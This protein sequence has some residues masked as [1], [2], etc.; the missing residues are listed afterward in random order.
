MKKA[1]IASL[2]ILALGLVFNIGAAS[3]QLPGTQGQV[4]MDAA[5]QADYSAAM[6]KLEG[7]PAQQ[8]PALEAYLAKYPKSGV[9]DYV[10]QKIMVDY[11][12]VDPAKAITAADNVLASTPDN[13]QAYVIEVAYRKQAAEALTDPAAKQ[14]GLDAAADF[15]RKGMTVKKGAMTDA[16]FAKLKDF[17]IPTFYATIGEDALNRKDSAAAVAA[18]KAEL[19]AMKPDQLAT[20]AA[21]QETYY[22][23]QAY[24]VATPPDYIN[25]TFYATRAA[26]LAPDQFKPQLQPLADYCY[27]KYHGG[28][29]GYDAVVTAAKASLTPPAN[30][31]TMITPAPTDKDIADKLMADTKD[32]DIP[33]LATG[34]KEYVLANASD[35]NKAKVWD[36]V[37]G[38]SYQIPGALV[39][40]SSPTV[41]K[42]AVSDDAIQAKKA[43]YTFNIKP[44]EAPEEPKVKTAVALAK[45]KKEKAAYDKQVA[46]I[47]AATAV[48]KT[49]T[50][51]GTY[52]SYTPNPIMII[53]TDGEVILPKAAPAAATPAHRVPAHK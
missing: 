47:A 37:K 39:I 7:K 42:A 6:D 12:Q 20:P 14:A 21:L 50:L 9:K 17:A 25:C 46:D 36:S 15:A 27:K 4:V 2:P 34:D 33:K 28:K 16:D 10:L 32:E 8:A 24:Y 35:A 5:E 23:A 13:L 44:L 3:A 11:S 40:E 43:D 29:D 41:I 48:G 30:I 22:L 52:D 19:A 1:S 45:Y 18:Y 49:V 53:M 31:A 51:A 26:A 38:K